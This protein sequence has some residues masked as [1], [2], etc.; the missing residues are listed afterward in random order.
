MAD[1]VA[2]FSALEAGEKDVL[3]GLLRDSLSAEIG[4]EKVPA[5]S[6]VPE[7]DF[8]VLLARTL[9]VRGFLPEDDSTPT[10]ARLT[11]GA[12]ELTARLS[13]I[14]GLASLRTPLLLIEDSWG[15]LREWSEASGLLQA[16]NSG[17]VVA[18]VELERQ[19]TLAQLQCADDV[20]ASGDNVIKLLK[21]RTT[22]L[23]AIAMC[24]LFLLLV[25][26]G[27]FELVRGAVVV[28]VTLMVGGICGPAALGYYALGR[29][30]AIPLEVQSHLQ[31]RENDYRQAVEE[32]KAA[33]M[34]LL[35][36]EIVPFATWLLRLTPHALRSIAAPKVDLSN[37]ASIWD[38]IDQ[39]IKE[40]AE[41]AQSASLNW[42]AAENRLLYFEALTP[43]G[44]AAI[45]ESA[46]TAR[47]LAEGQ[48]QLAR[49][50]EQGV[51]DAQERSETE[52]RIASRLS[53]DSDAEVS[54]RSDLNALKHRFERS[55]E[56]LSE[57]KNRL[58]VADREESKAQGEAKRLSG[59]ET[60]LPQTS[61]QLASARAEDARLA[62]DVA[63]VR[64]QVNSAAGEDRERYL[65]EL[66]Q[67]ERQH[68]SAARKV[69]ELSRRVK[70]LEEDRQKLSECEAV[71]RDWQQRK[72]EAGLDVERH[73]E[74]AK[75]D[76]RNAD[77]VEQK[78]GLATTERQQQLDA[79]VAASKRSTGECDRL[80]SQQDGY[81]S[82][83]VDADRKAADLVAEAARYANDLARKAEGVADWTDKVAG[84]AEVSDRANSH[85]SELSDTHVTRRQ[86]TL[87]LALEH[88]VGC[89]VDATGIGY[90]EQIP[91]ATIE[92]IAGAATEIVASAHPESLTEGRDSQGDLLYQFFADDSVYGIV[93][94][95]QAETRTLSFGA[96]VAP[97]T[98]APLEDTLPKVRE[99]LDVIVARSTAAMAKL[100]GSA[101]PQPASLAQAQT[102]GWLAV[103]LGFLGAHRYYLAAKSTTPGRAGEIRTP[104]F[105]LLAVS[106]TVIGL[107]LSWGF[108][109]YEGVRL[110]SMEPLAFDGAFLNKSPKRL[111]ETSAQTSPGV[112][113]PA[114]QRTPPVAP[115]TPKRR[116]VAVVVALSAV[117]LAACVVASMATQYRIFQPAQTPGAGQLGGSQSKQPVKPPSATPADKMDPAIAAFHAWVAS[118]GGNILA[119]AIPA[120]STIPRPTFAT[121][122]YQSA[123]QQGNVFYLSPRMPQIGEGSDWTPLKTSLLNQVDWSLRNGFTVAVTAASLSPLD[124]TYSMQ[125][126]DGNGAP[127]SITGRVIGIYQ[128]VSVY[129][130]S[131][132][133]E[134]HILMSRTNK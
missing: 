92:K 48:R 109:M 19:R 42:L 96:G 86:Q 24:F 133:L 16:H 94:T 2:G 55:S 57:A 20:A 89:T 40:V 32:R 6:P 107:P 73:T 74:G 127:V 104:G 56:A 58:Q 101:Y 26:P 99:R 116:A 61:G 50:M 110:T 113:G 132:N 117:L 80:R 47:A 46:A 8:R 120:T 85:L 130:G 129:K 95:G 13:G 124:V 121:S 122:D 9:R 102:A 3:L 18:A 70:T 38:L 68:E 44:H 60:E 90:L 118:R 67:L 75:T 81:S 59:V 52:Q 64:D 65:S 28:G 49:G 112:P 108:A 125:G 131:S 111:P 15:S 62:D 119:G 33:A 7:E 36:S 84:C 34:D 54:L 93:L 51:R 128:G 17:G 98:A 39:E 5:T 69:E 11:R 31:Q 10:D 45:L 126:T 43:E 14:G 66:S 30:K 41:G 97:S 29:V 105:A 123:I 71:L 114:A 12:A 72:R 76:K 21:K 1:L 103:G 106:A 87:K 77:A 23:A 35:R 115:V 22:L 4:A 88:G 100:H 91:V 25:I 78:L 53:H 37:M 79:A 82:A 134:T 83:A 63:R 27:V